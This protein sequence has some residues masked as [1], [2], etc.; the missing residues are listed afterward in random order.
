MNQLVLL[1]AV[2]DPSRMARVDRTLYAQPKLRGLHGLG[3]LE[4][5]DALGLAT[6][7]LVVG[8]AVGFALGAAAVA[9]VR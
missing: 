4:L 6:L 5:M 8:G 9:S 1:P 3:E 2:L 7:A